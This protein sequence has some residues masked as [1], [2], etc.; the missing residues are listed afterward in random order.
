MHT[1]VYAF[2]AMVCFIA[3]RHG[4]NYLTTRPDYLQIH[5]AIV[6]YLK[7]TTNWAFLSLLL[8]QPGQGEY[9]LVVYL[10]TNMFKGSEN[11]DS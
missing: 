3:Y 6:S 1:Y 4:I 9:N 10:M 2:S 5:L 11:A 8:P 7:K